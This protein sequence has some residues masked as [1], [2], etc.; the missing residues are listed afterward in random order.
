MLPELPLEPLVVRAH[1]SM[2][3]EDEVEVVRDRLLRVEE[4]RQV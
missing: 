3:G 1:P 4:C 2:H